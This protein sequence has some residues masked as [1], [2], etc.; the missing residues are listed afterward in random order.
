[1][2][3]MRCIAAWGGA[4]EGGAGEDAPPTLTLAVVAVGHRG[5][6]LRLDLGALQGDDA[7]Q[8]AGHVAGLAVG[9]VEQEASLQKNTQN[10]IGARSSATAATAVASG[11]GIGQRR[12]PTLSTKYRSS[13]ACRECPFFKSTPAC[14]TGLYRDCVDMMARQ[15]E[16]CHGARQALERLGRWLSDLPLLKIS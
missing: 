5:R 10:A 11:G 7:V 9:E 15:S 4:G 13:H 2:V 6:Q 12:G 16:V 3:T 8:L 1:M 14:S